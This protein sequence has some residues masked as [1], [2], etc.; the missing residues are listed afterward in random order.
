MKS[1]DFLPTLLRR[2]IYLLWFVFVL[3]FVWFLTLKV[4]AYLEFWNLENC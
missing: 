2:G 3:V 4:G 1:D